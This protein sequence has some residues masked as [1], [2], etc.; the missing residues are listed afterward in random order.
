MRGIEQAGIAYRRPHAL[1]RVTWEK[2][3]AHPASQAKAEKPQ[4]TRSAAQTLGEGH[5]KHGESAGEKPGEALGGVA[6]L[7]ALGEEVKKRE[8]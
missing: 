8:L 6:L 2:G 1:R 4:E 7:D 3:V 5:S